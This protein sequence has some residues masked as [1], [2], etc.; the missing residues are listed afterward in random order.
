MCKPD[1]GCIVFLSGEVDFI[2]V[3]K[4]TLNGVPGP[5]TFDEMVPETRDHYTWD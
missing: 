4:K 3:K 1:I 2:D 5:G